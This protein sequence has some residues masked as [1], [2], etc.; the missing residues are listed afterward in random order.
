MLKQQ[1]TCIDRFGLDNTGIVQY[2]FNQ[3]GFRASKDFN[4]A[5]DHAFFGCS[6]VF[7]IGVPENLTFPSL[8]ENSQNY[9]LAGSYNNADIM[10]VLENFLQSDLYQDSVKIAVFWHS[11]QD[12][13][14]PEYYQQ[15]KDHD[16]IHFFCGPVLP[17]KRCYRFPSNQDFDASGTHPGIKSHK[18]IC[19]ALNSLFQ[20]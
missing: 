5:P 4:F 20:Q 11:R 6:L 3:Q 1:G 12:E 17:Y 15:L 19:K 13:M 18:F 8:F 16:M 2:Q 14:L 9:G 10:I 7:G